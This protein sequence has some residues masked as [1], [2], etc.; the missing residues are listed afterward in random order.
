MDPEHVAQTKRLQGGDQ[1]TL[2]E[3]RNSLVRSAGHRQGL[4]TERGVEAVAQENHRLRGTHPSQRRVL[5]VGGGQGGTMDDP[6][7]LAPPE[8]AAGGN[9]G[10]ITLYPAPK[11]VSRRR[12]MPALTSTCRAR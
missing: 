8:K 7:P 2:I 3:C 10:R 5:G 12:R 11:P 4:R 6:A 1:G 9:Y